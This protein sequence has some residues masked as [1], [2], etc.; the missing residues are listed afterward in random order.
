VEG[1][2]EEEEQEQR[3]GQAGIRQPF[4]SCLAPICFARAL[5]RHGDAMIG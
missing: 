1:G 5:V 4:G 2:G 3:P